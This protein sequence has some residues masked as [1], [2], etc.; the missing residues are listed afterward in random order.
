MTSS[1]AAVRQQA[2]TLPPARLLSRV[3]D[4]IQLTDP[5]NPPKWI[6]KRGLSFQLLCGFGVPPTAR[7]RLLPNAPLLARLAATGREAD[8]LD[9][10]RR[11]EQPDAR[12]DTLLAGAEADPAGLPALE[13]YA[14]A[15]EPAPLLATVHLPDWLRRHTV[16]RL[17][18]RKEQSSADHVASI[19]NQHLKTTGS[20]LGFHSPV[21]LVG[22]HAFASDADLPLDVTRRQ[23]DSLGSLLGLVAIALP[24]GA[25]SDEVTRL[26]LFQPTTPLPLVRPYGT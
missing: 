2:Q 13:E 18:P 9:L 15:M 14:G 12:L 5:A 3:A 21:R 25:W 16:R 11:G 19:L 6:D 10:L 26:L 4:S 22:R 23:A 24:R 8:L 17:R 1:Y 7:L 20:I